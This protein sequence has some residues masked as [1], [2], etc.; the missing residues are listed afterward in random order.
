MCCSGLGV[1]TPRDASQ[2]P[3]DHEK[4][5]F[6]VK[7]LRSPAP[8]KLP[9]SLR[10][11]GGAV[12]GAGPSQPHREVWSSL[13]GLR[14][15][16]LNFTLDVD[17]LKERKRLQCADQRTCQSCLREWGSGPRF[18]ES[19]LLSP[20]EGEVSEGLRKVQR[21]LCFDTRTE[22]CAMKGMYP[23]IQTRQLT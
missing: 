1:G 9:G 4:S 17:V 15:T 18:C 2:V 5:T 23:S 13:P 21:G 6:E 22:G 8:G 14:G 7:K 3:E 12:S 19:R 10:R 11:A 20:T 16:S